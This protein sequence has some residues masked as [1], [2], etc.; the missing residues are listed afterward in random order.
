[1][2]KTVTV[3]LAA[4]L[5]LFVFSSCDG[6]LAGNG[7]VS[8]D[9]IPGLSFAYSPVQK[10]RGIYLGGSDTDEELAYKLMLSFSPVFTGFS[11]QVSSEGRTEVTFTAPAL[12]TE[13]VINARILDDR[14]EYEGKNVEKKEG[15]QITAKEGDSIYFKITYYPEE[16]TFDIYQLISAW[17]GDAENKI[18]FVAKVQGEGIKVDENGNY[19]GTLV[20]AEAVTHVSYDKIKSVIYSDDDMMISVLLEGPGRYASQDDQMVPVDDTNILREEYFEKLIEE[21]KD[22]PDRGAVEL[23]GILYYERNSGTY[24]IYPSSEFSTKEEKLEYLA[25]KALEITGGK[26]DISPLTEELNL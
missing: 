11:G 14:I 4:I 8:A 2:K 5:I 1:M 15:N 10:A 25:Q 24:G 26:L 6:S 9:S 19:D 17:E 21:R 12:D 13:V 16:S 18:P 22:M 23:Y 7:Q 20:E 3:L